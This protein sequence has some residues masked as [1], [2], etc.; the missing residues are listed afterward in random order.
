MSILMLTQKISTKSKM[1]E[2]SNFV[3]SFK[4]KLFEERKT[5]E[6]YWLHKSSDLLASA[7]VLWDSMSSGNKEL[8]ERLGFPSE[9]SFSASNYPA[10]KLIVGLSLELKIK[11]VIVS[12]GEKPKH[13]HN[14]NKLAEYADIKIDS[15]EQVLFEMLSEVI[16]W[17]GK[18]PVPDTEAKLFDQWNRWNSGIT[19][20]EKDGQADITKE[21]LKWE[22]IKILW[23]KIQT[24]KE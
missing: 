12:K 10:Y 4:T 17:E 18:Y 15:N 13:I 22:N 7:G 2:T 21:L 9:F 3:S 19:T 6:N 14:L 8:K 5:N 1:T 16:Y 11:A 20:I 23:G 24:K